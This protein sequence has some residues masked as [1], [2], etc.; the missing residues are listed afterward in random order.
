MRGNGGGQGDVFRD[1]N[2]DDA[3][4]VGDGGGDVVFGAVGLWW[5]KLAVSS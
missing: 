3:E 1:V 4:L 2:I 5:W